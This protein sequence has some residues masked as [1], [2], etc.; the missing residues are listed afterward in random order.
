MDGPWDMCPEGERMIA[1]QK[2]METQKTKNQVMRELL[3]KERRRRL[4][5]TFNIYSDAQQ[6]VFIGQ[7]KAIDDLRPLFGEIPT[8]PPDKDLGPYLA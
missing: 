2:K 7:S 6:S 1:R 8:A 3:G 5:G 4:E